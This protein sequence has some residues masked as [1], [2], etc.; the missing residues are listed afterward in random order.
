MEKFYI[1]TAIAYVNA[2]PHIGHA[3]E[4]TQADAI[5]RYFR[6]MGRDVFFLT[7]T[8][9][10]GMKI[11]QTAREKG[12]APIELADENA[13][14][15]RALC[16]K[17]QMSYDHFI[18]TSE[19][20]HKKGVQ[21]IWEKI[22]EAGKFYEKEYEGLYCIGC[23][24][25]VLEKDLVDGLCP[26]HQ[27]PPEK[28]KEKNYFFKLSD[29]SDAIREKIKSGELKILP[30][31]K[32]KEFLSFM[33]DGLS[34]VS[35]S[36][37]KKTLEWGVLVPGDPDQVMYVWCDALSNYITGVGYGGNEENLK[38]W[39]ADVHLIGK[40]IM[41]FHCG[42]WIG[43]LMAAGLEL[44]KAIY[45]HGFITSEGKK[46]SKSL[47]NVVDPMEVLEKWGVDALRYYLLREIPT[48]D[49]GDFSRE[50]F[51]IIYREEL[52]N[53]I[54]NLVRRVAAMVQK[55]FDGKVPEGNSEVGGQCDE[56]C[57]KFR[58]G[59]ESFN[60]KVAIEAALRL[61]QNANAYVEQNKPWELAKNHPE[62]LSVVMGNLVFIC[63]ELAE[64]LEPI[65]PETSAKI[66]KSIGGDQVQVG[67]PLF[68]SIE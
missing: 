46:M 48:A 6:K 68:P 30:E 1:S 29:Y 16:D 59:M 15:I 47:G 63:R 26:N 20:Y 24:A 22:D 52:A 10:H 55:Y 57:E 28:L 12:I 64:M 14:K 19:E 65:I 7:G 58:N 5:A 4:F 9:E 56:E 54:G 37:P 60:I 44:P 35:F 51:E 43:M 34:D 23:E 31:S 13:G 66:K 38:Y 25:F 11:Q 17:L 41:R 32:K 39:P 3:L 50:R 53:T 33:E 2:P 61:A 67:E 27:K 62:R 21:K 8:D 36:R 49:D 45:I 42:I 18:R 40:D